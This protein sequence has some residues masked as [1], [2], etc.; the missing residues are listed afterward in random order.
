MKLLK[1]VVKPLKRAE[2]VRSLNAPDACGAM[3]DVAACPDGESTHRL[4]RGRRRG[5]QLEYWLLWTGSREV[6]FVHLEPYVKAEIVFRMEASLA[7]TKHAVKRVRP[8]PGRGHPA[9]EEYCNAV[10]MHPKSGVRRYRDTTTVDCAPGI[11]AIP[12]PEA[13]SMTHAQ[14]LRVETSANPVA[15][16]IWTVSLLR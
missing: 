8:V 1:K 5:V 2:K 3:P 9:A 13:V 6:T 16:K 11:S 4:S 15:P 7:S 12:T 10:G 14:V